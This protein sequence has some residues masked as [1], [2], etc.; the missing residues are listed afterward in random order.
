MQA[1]FI[2]LEEVDEWQNV[3]AIIAMPNHRSSP[4]AIQLGLTMIDGSQFRIDFPESAGYSYFQEVGLT[5]GFVFIGFGEFVFV[6][7]LATKSI[8][9]YEL[10]GYFGHL[11]SAEELNASSMDFAMLV[12]SASEVL[13]F[14]ALGG[15]QW[16]AR[17]LAVDGVLV[18]SVKDGVIFGTAEWDPP[19]GWQSFAL[20]IKTG[21]LLQTHQ[22]LRGATAILPT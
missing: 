19:G 9:A 15:L 6:F 16:T 4:L 22:A 12:C 7:A 13:S 5:E 18:E 2:S 14:S 3:E 11:Y 10:N 17:N 8:S 20:A 21:E 1:K